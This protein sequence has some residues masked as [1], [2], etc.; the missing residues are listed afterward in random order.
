M[1]TTHSIPTLISNS[2]T[3][4]YLYYQANA[5]SKP[6]FC[7]DNPENPLTFIVAET[8]AVAAKAYFDRVTKSVTKIGNDEM[9]NLVAKEFLTLRKTGE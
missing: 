6:A 7:V 1:E 9:S 4:S 8:R 3:E 2:F 5:A